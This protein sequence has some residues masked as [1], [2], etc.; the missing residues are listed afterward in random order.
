MKETDDLSFY[1]N[2]LLTQIYC[3][4]QLQNSE[5][6]IASIFRSINPIRNGKKLFEFKITDYGFEPD[7]RFNFSTEWTQD[8]IDCN[9]GLFTELFHFQLLK[10]RE[11]IKNTV[12]GQE[13]QG[14]ILVAEI[15]NTVTDGA[16]EVCSDGLVDVYDYPPID[17]WFHLEKNPNG[18]LLF[19]W[20]PKEF[21]YN[22]NEA[23]AVN[24]MDCLYWYDEQQIELKEKEEEFRVDNSEKSFYNKMRQFLRK[25]KL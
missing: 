9:S 23:I 16:S 4:R 21:V 5:K 3:D 6:N 17:T 8:P 15:D 10:K 11:N 12:S 18:R 13:F 1:E 14:R 25:K 7:T 19:A 20:I 24:C 22:A 2:L